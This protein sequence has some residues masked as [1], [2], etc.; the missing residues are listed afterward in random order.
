MKL[1]QAA[2]LRAQ[3]STAATTEHNVEEEKDDFQAQSVAIVSGK[4]GV[5]KSN[6]TVNF[7]IQLA[8][9]QKKVLL[10]DMD[11]GM[12]NVHI[13]L[14]TQPTANLKQY[15]MGERSLEQVIH[16]YQTNFSYI[17]GGSGLDELI[18]WTDE[19][20]DRL[21]SAFQQMQTVYDFILFDMGAGATKRTMDLIAAVDEVIVISTPEPTSI[22]DAYSMMKF[23]VMKDFNKSIHIIN[24]RVP[25]SEE[26]HLVAKRLQLAMKKFLNKE[27]TILGSLKEDPLVMEAVI[28]QTPFVLYRPKAK[29][30][31]QLS[32]ITWTFIG[33]QQPS[34]EPKQL[35]N[36]LKRFFMKG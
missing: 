10:I 23:I 31:Q 9:Q 7:A 18:E 14:G 5:G 19:R 16:P 34:S 27:V 2:K 21:L 12:G 22:T 28:A 36:R 26:N 25:R 17:S 33:V 8:A 15:L 30:V 3:M 29:I 32:D 1:D 4:G 6:F 35:L 11:L 20:V 13:L 24:N